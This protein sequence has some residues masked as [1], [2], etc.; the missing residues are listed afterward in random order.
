[1][2][3]SDENIRTAAYYIWLAEGQPEGLAEAHWERA[4]ALLGGGGPA[5]KRT[6]PRSKSAAEASAAPARTTRKA[7][8]K[9]ATA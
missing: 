5:P 1:M 3:G 6:R 2:T 4:S 9:K 8:R 7:T